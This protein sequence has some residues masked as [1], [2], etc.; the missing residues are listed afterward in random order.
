[1]RNCI[2]CCFSDAGIVAGWSDAPAA[3]WAVADVVVTGWQRKSYIASRALALR[4]RKGAKGVADLKQKP[5]TGTGACH[6]LKDRNA[7]QV[8][9]KGL[10]AGFVAEYGASGIGAK[11]APQK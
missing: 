3:I 9:A 7:M 6:Q 10:L 2:L 8:A 5:A 1:M 11:G 4:T